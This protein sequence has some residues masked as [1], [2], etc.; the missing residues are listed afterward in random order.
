MK[1]KVKH[2]LSDTNDEVKIAHER[3][4]FNKQKSDMCFL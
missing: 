1:L 4:H 3:A 2:N